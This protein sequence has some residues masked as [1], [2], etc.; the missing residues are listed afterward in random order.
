MKHFAPP[1][2]NLLATAFHQD[3]IIRVSVT[4]P[5]TGLTNRLGY[6]HE[7]EQI[8][9]RA[10]RNNEPFTLLSMDLTG[11]KTINDTYGHDAGDNVLIR[12]AAALKNVSRAG[13][14]IVRWGG[15]EF[16]AIL[17]GATTPEA[18]PAV[19]RFKDAVAGI[20]FANHQLG[21]DIGT[22]SYPVDALTITELQSI[23]DQRMYT[24]KEKGKQRA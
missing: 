3:E 1:V 10:I 4:D 7:I 21:I 18:E 9:A 12:V 2:A 11:F 24:R 15:D 22:A 16:T 19:E 13:D 5:L 14:V 17:P 8:H 6:Q 23:A 20:H